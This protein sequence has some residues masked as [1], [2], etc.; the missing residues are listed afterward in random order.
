MTTETKSSDPGKDEP[1]V[2]EPYS[3][4]RKLAFVRMRSRRHGIE[5]DDEAAAYMATLFDLAAAGQLPPGFQPDYP[6]FDA[7]RQ[8][9]G[10]C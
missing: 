10:H 8:D 6:D 9:G 1:L 7:H 2:G 4:E 5:L 3:M